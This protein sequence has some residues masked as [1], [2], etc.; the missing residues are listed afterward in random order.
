MWTAICAP[1]TEHVCVCV[2]WLYCLVD[3]TSQSGN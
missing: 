3:T 2:C 1:T